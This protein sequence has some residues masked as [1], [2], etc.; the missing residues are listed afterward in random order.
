MLTFMPDLESCTES[1]H[2]FVD[3]EVGLLQ[4]GLLEYVVSYITGFL[5]KS[6]NLWKYV[7]S[8]LVQLG[9][10]VFVCKVLNDDAVC[11]FLWSSNSLHVL[12]WPH[13]PIRMYN[14]HLI[15]KHCSIKD[16]NAFAVTH[17]DRMCSVRQRVLIEV[18]RRH[19]RS[20]W[21]KPPV[22]YRRTS[23]L[24]LL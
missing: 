22:C 2:L 10:S 3:G 20:Q 5:G 13:Y 1:T 11:M 9:T 24:H 21:R 4:R 7:K 6:S 17:S 16:W 8:F 12:D 23:N 19:M 15:N 14:H 18:I